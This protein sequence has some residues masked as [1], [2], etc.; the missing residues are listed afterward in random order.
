MSV[1]DLE[2]EKS[3]HDED[4]FNRPSNERRKSSMSRRKN[5]AYEDPFSKSYDEEEGEVNE[6]EIDFQSL[7]WWYV[8]NTHNVH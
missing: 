1:A 8:A 6:T 4:V 5:S 7:E 2:K 3:S